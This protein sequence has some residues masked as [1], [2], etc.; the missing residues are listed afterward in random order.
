VYEYYQRPEAWSVAPGAV[1]ALKRLRASGVRL[2]VVS[3][4]D[5]RLVPLMDGLGLTPLFDEIVV[6]AEVGGGA[7]GQGILGF[8]AGRLI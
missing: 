1:S 3:N 7:G 6:S 2:A 8:G 5:T 4:F